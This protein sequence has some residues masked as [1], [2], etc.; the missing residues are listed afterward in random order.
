MHHERLKCRAKAPHILRWERERE[1]EVCL[2]HRDRYFSAV[3]HPSTLNSRFDVKNLYNKGNRSP[4]FHSS[5][6]RAGSGQE[7]KRAEQNRS[8]TFFP[9][10]PSHCHRSFVSQIA[11]VAGEGGNNDAPGFKKPVVSV[12]GYGR[13]RAG[14]GGEEGEK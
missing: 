12:A 1:R 7:E 6:G 13:S 11:A 9:P 4:S 3:L 10:L 8:T 2:A 14:A 5:R